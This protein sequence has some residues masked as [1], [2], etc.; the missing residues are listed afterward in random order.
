M[1]NKDCNVLLL[2]WCIKRVELD[3]CVMGYKMMMMKK[4]YILIIFKSLWK[5]KLKW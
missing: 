4:I 3:N 2:I 5:I 1:E